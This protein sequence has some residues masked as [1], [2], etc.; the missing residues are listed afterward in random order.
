[1]F[2]MYS[3]R[4]LYNNVDIVASMISIYSWLKFC[5]MQLLTVCVVNAFFFLFSR[6][7]GRA[8]LLCECSQASPIKN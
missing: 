4:S 2:K 6:I 5:D 8:P 7:S 1:M 3:S